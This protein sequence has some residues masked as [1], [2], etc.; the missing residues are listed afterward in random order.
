MHADFQ[1]FFIGFIFVLPVS[2]RESLSKLSGVCRFLF[3]YI[4]LN[5]FNRKI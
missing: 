5:G 1:N 3:E 4:I 2:I